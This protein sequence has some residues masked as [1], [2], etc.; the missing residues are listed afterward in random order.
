MGF[1]GQD[2]LTFGADDPMCCPSQQ[3]AQTYALQGGQRVQLR[4]QILGTAQP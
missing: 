4:S 3:E 1:F 2:R